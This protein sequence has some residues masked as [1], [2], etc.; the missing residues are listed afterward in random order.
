MLLSV[1][2][3]VLG[4]LALGGGCSD[5]GPDYENTTPFPGPCSSR[6]HGSTSVDAY[7]FEYEQGRLVFV[8][9]DTDSGWEETTWQ[10]NAD[11]TP[12]L[13]SNRGSSMP[14]SDRVVW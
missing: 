12:A 2:S 14:E 5:Y 4:V 9:A 13:I 10:W 1:R 3:I 6:L 11:G 7:T 8:R